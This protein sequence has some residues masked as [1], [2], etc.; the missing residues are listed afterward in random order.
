MSSRPQQRHLEAFAVAR[1]LLDD[2]AA[3]RAAVIATWNDLERDDMFEVWLDITNDGHGELQAGSFLP[4]QAA[5]TVSEHAAA[6]LT[7]VKDA[8]DAAVLATA[9]TVCA[10]LWPVDP[11]AHR[12]PL[13][14]TPAEFDALV[15]DGQLLGLRPDQ[16]RTLRELQPFTNGSPAAQFISLQMS[17][18]TA[19]LAALERGERLVCAWAT[20]T[21][22][23][24]RLPDGVTLSSLETASDGPLTSP[25]LLATI[26]VDPPQA[27]ER[28]DVLPNVALDMILNVPPWPANMDDNF[29]A[30][31]SNLLIAARHLIEGLE[32]S[33]STPTFIQQY[34]R[35]DDLAPFT[36][37]TVWK[38]VLF[39]SAEQEIEVREGLAQSD[40]NLASIRGDDGTYTLLRLDGEAVVGREIPDANPPEPA[41]AL[42]PGTE[43]AAL[44]AAAEWGLPDFVFP[45]KTVD[46]GSGRRELGDGTILSGRR[47]ISIQVKARDGATDSVIRESNWLRK[48]A[49]E[50]LRQAHGTIR[51]K[52]LDRTLTMTNLRGREIHTP[53]EGVEWVPV[54]I[55]DHPGPPHDVIPD[56]ERDKSGLILLRRDWEFLW[57]QLRSA[58]AIVEYAHRVADDERVALGSEANRYFDLADKDE[59]AEP[60]QLPGWLVDAG[61]APT[62]GPTLPRDPVATTDTFGH[63]VFDRI[64]DDIAA[65]DFTGDEWTRLEIL[66][67]IDRLWVGHRAELGRMLLRRIDH[68]SLAPAD[69]LRAQHRITFIDA[70]QLQLSFSVYSQFTGYHQQLF[71]SW[72]LHRRQTFLQNSGATGPEYPWTVAVLLT[73]R[74]DGTRLWD[75]TVLATISGP[76][77]DD[78]EYETI[79]RA[80]AQPGAADETVL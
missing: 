68:C 74:P 2:A 9:Q 71:Q 5:A 44:D 12:M 31:S 40:L 39:D 38:P 61:A 4:E 18:L 57:N 16:V 49:G 19:A 32:R 17:H 75:T 47:G 66:A 8:M 63:G 22:P 15:P 10:P 25:R 36:S 51:Q 43:L 52:L 13:A 24:V 27:I 14:G 45:A 48:K 77:Y 28:V 33:V 65:T 72:A 21:G 54:V 3:S 56:R 46:K 11:E 73:P 1:S 62:T 67:L 35:I 69:E 70:G 58:S 53:S 60:T 79:D 29:Q 23:E 37:S 80:F 30:R 7:T 64:L 42:G 20:H 78:E 41:M 50:G 6:F 26:R 34:G 76:A 59:R 55:L